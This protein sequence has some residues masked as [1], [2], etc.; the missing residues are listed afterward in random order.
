[1]FT[2]RIFSRNITS[3]SLQSVSEFMESNLGYSIREI[4]TNI[5][6]EAND[7]IT[8]HMRTTYYYMKENNICVLEEGFSDFI[9]NIK[10][11]FI[12]MK[13]I[14]IDFTKKT[15]SYINSYMIDFDN[16][17]NKYKKELSTFDNDFY[18]EDAFEYTF[19][20]E[21]PNISIVHKLINEFNNDIQN[22]NKMTNEYVEDKKMHFFNS[23]LRDTIRGSIIKTKKEIPQ[24]QY[25]EEVKKAYRN[26]KSNPTKVFVNKKYIDAIINS[27]A[28]LK[29]NLKYTIIMRDEI[30]KSIDL[31]LDILDKQVKF[32]D[33]FI[34][35]NLLTKSKTNAKST[36]VV[37]DKTNEMVEILNKYYHLAFR[38]FETIYGFINT[39]YFEK[40]NAIR[41]CMV[42]NVKI[43]RTARLQQLNVVNVEVVEEE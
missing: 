28:D 36:P 38:K 18:Y 3:N 22:C 2:Q 25:I 6:E 12:K 9:N 31:I 13:R 21:I 29:A 14:I 23:N 26:K 33:E 30:L 8:S 40:I 5:I 41:E 39:A 17:I 1:M 34:Y 10:V 27:N 19:K 43:I 15:F 11:F 24:T 32:D 20:K 4:D 35:T 7:I 16:I 37:I 42:Q